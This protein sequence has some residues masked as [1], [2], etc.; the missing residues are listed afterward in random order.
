MTFAF[1]S[2]WTADGFGEVLILREHALEFI[3]VYVCGP[4]ICSAMR[5]IV[6]KHQEPEERQRVIDYYRALMEAYGKTGYRIFL[7]LH[8]ILR[9]RRWGTE[10]FPEVCA[11]IKRALASNGILSPGRYSI[12]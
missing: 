7:S 6:F 11:A 5:V 9:K 4:R 2:Q 3:T 1:Q 10:T 12:G 8:S